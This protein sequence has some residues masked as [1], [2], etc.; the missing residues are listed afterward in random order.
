MK[1]S[2][3]KIPED[4]GKVFRLILSTIVFSLGLYIS[5]VLL[6][7]IMNGEMFSKFSVYT[8]SVNISEKVDPKGFWITASF[9]VLIASALF[10]LSLAEM[11]YTFKK[12]RSREK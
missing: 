10:Y 5:F 2:P 3:M 12:Y 9:N 7:G 4:R 1:S 8:D 6:K 11:L